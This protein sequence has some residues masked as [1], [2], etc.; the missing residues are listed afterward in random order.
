MFLLSFVS[1]ESCL[2]GRYEHVILVEDSTR[3]ED[4][5]ARNLF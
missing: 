4:T 5:A 2:H 1:L 3:F